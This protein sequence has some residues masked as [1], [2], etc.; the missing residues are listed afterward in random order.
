MD[1]PREN[2]AQQQNVSDTSNTQVAQ[3]VYGDIY[4]YQVNDNGKLFNIYI[5]NPDRTGGLL[6]DKLQT[7]D[8]FEKPI[9]FIQ[10]LIFLVKTTINWLFIGFR[11]KYKFPFNT[12]THLIA[13]VITGDIIDEVANLQIECNKKLV[14][15]IEALNNNN[16]EQISIEE[17][18]NLEAKLEVCMRLIEDLAFGRI[19]DKEALAEFW[20]EVKTNTDWFSREIAEEKRNHYKKLY[21]IQNKQK[22]KSQDTQTQIELHIEKLT[23]LMEVEIPSQNFIETL[24]QETK[25]L[26]KRQMSIKDIYSI[27]NFVRFLEQI[28]IKLKET[29]NYTSMFGELKPLRGEFIGIK[30]LKYHFSRKCPHWWSALGKYLYEN[31]DVINGS[32]SDIFPE[33]MDPCG[34]CQKYEPNYHSQQQSENE[35]NSLELESE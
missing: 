33:N 12:V 14:S 27:Q 4:Q 34:D 32:S 28:S 11:A 30:N 21:E 22:Q 19:E 8:F 35:C 23:R 17:K 16:S 1:T 9:N 26:E 29:Q 3:A 13:S 2:P 24:I 18:I 6:K 15:L 5:S 10:V 25:Q 7:V 20:G 31:E